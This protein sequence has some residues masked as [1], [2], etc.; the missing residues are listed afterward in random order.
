M[1]DAGHEAMEFAAG[2]YR[3]DLD[4]NRMLVLSLVKIGITNR[5]TWLGLSTV[6]DERLNRRSSH[7]GHREESTHA[8]RGV[9]V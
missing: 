2:Q 5:P 4:T 1:I 8:D 9:T 7:S 3:A 6:H